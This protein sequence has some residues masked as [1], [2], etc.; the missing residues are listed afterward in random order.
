MEHLPLIHGILL[1]HGYMHVFPEKRGRFLLALRALHIWE[2]LQSSAEGGPCC[3]E[4][5]H[6]M[7]KEMIKQGFVDAAI[8]AETALDAYLREQDWDQL[9][10]EDIAIDRRTAGS[11]SVALLFGR[12]HR[13]E[14]VKT[15]Q[16]QGVKIESPLLVLIL[17]ER[18]ARM[19]PTDKVFRITS[20][21]F[22]QQ[23]RKA[24]VALGMPWFP[25]PHSLRHSG[26]SEDA[27][28]G[29]RS[30]EDI[31]RRGRWLQAKSVQRYAK[32]HALIVHRA[33]V[34]KEIM[35]R[36]AHLEKHFETMLADTVDTDDPWRPALDS[37]RRIRRK[38][39]IELVFR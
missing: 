30:M 4:S 19:Q 2:D 15:G 10:A 11:P 14:S 37:A 29:R 17:A 25:P 21:T 27:T 39:R 26:P 28:T 13:G 12:R 32:P 33:R 7:A 9:L 24:A 36:G 38:E 16:E 35:A 6:A 20:D 22:R 18:A 34:P 23:W 8:A 5:V 3:R 31:R 1:Y